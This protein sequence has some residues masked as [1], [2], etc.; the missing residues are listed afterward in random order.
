MAGFNHS[1]HWKSNAGFELALSLA[2]QGNPTDTRSAFRQAHGRASALVRR[3]AA[4]VRQ[5]TK[6]NPW[7]PVKRME[8]L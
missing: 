6:G 8:R 4:L 2:G 3:A 5:E 1:D 7:Q